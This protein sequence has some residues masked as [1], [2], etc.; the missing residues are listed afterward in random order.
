MSSFLLKL[1]RQCWTA[2]FSPF[3][4]ST[5]AILSWFLYAFSSILRCFENL[6]D[7]FALYNIFPMAFLNMI[8][9]IIDSSNTPFCI[10]TLPFPQLFLGVILAILNFYTSRS[11]SFSKGLCWAVL[12]SNW[13]D[14][15]S[16][17]AFTPPSE[18]SPSSSTALSLF[19]SSGFLVNMLFLGSPNSEFL[20]LNK[21]PPAGGL[22]EKSD[23]CW[24][25]FPKRPPPL[26][27]PNKDFG[28]APSLG[29][30]NKLP[31]VKPPK[32]PVPE[33]FVF[34]ALTPP[35]I[36]GLSSLE[37]VEEKLN[38]L[39]FGGLVVVFPN[40]LVP[41]GKVVVNLN[42]VEGF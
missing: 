7:R 34:C 5:T 35:K 33:L 20:A 6:G 36:D 17:G 1:I 31:P 2:G 4:I 41:A 25:L 8:L 18:F 40:K 15:G 9:Y 22:E 32:R 11:K 29:G 37:L 19:N 39:L 13:R 21:L 24:P 23:D 16:S 27:F 12:S 26:G 3:S 28:Y 42:P 10:E 14:G 30:A 38:K